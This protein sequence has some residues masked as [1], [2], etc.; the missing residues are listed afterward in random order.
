MAIAWSSRSGLVALLS[1]AVFMQMIVATMMGP[2]LVPL[3]SAFDTSVAAAGQLAAAIGITW[4]ITAPLVGPVSDIYGRRTV[5]LVGVATIAAGTIGSLLVW[6][7]WGL[8]GCR[9]LTGVGA[10]MIPPNS[11]ATI[12]DHFAPEERGRPMS[13][14]VSSWNFSYVVGLPAVAALGAFGGWRPPFI[15]VGALLAALLAWHWYAFPEGATAPRALGFG[16]HFNAVMRVPA[17]WFVLVANVLFRTA[18]FAIFTYLVAFLVAAYGVNQGGTALPLALVGIGAMLGSLFGGYLAGKPQR[19]VL[20]AL[21][22]FGGGLGIAIAF[23]ADLSPWGAA[24][25]GCAGTL[26]LG[27]FEPVSWVLIAEL[28]GQSRATANGLLATSNQLGVIG[29]G[30]VGGLVLAF[31]G[32]TALGLF[33]LASAV[34]AAVIVIGMDFRLRAGRMAGVHER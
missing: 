14:M 16:S 20:A 18:S 9:L 24:M 27:V 32:F 29:G 30:S 2:L 23:D 11:M 33:C 12:A 34:T 17:L 15:V 8:L 1:A 21:G 6:D 28:A 5:A 22:L 3:A 19:L 31:G 13:I 25:A 4:G 26:M 7:Y 10:A